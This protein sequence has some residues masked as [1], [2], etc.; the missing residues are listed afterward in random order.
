MNKH[1]VSTVGFWSALLAFLFSN[2]FTVGAVVG[3]MLP[4]PWDA[5]LPVAPSLL[6]APTFAI[7]MVALHRAAPED[8]KIWSH[9][10]LV[11]AMLYAVIA[12]IVYVTWLFVLEP[13]VMQ[14]T[15]ASVPAFAFGPGTFLQM[16]DGI[17][18]FYSC[19]AAFFTVPIFAHKG[20]ERWLRWTAIANGI[21]AIPV[22]LSYIYFNTALGIWWSLTIPLFTILLAIYFRRES[23]LVQPSLS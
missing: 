21:V 2:T 12:S 14:G 18:Y 13:H 10:A 5:I 19:L 1:A 6:L 17:A 7:M 11:I 3:G 16:L 20:L 9:I 4:K 8:K 22:F 23:R 15:Q